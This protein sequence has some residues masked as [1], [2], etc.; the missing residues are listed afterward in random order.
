[1]TSDADTFEV[2]RPSLLALAYRM[3]GEMGRVEISD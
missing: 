2:H 3:L 1:M